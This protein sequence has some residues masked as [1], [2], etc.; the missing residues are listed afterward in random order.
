MMKRIFTVF[1]L[2]FVVA[3]PVLAELKVDIVAGA[4]EPIAIAVQKFETTD[5][6]PF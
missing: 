6:V 3:Q 2:L 4:A 5:G 1:V